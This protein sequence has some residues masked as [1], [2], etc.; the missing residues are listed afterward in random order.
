MEREPDPSEIF[1]RSMFTL[2]HQWKRRLDD[3]FRHLGLTQARWGVLIALSTCDDVTQI[4]LAR[5]MGI[6][7]ASLVRLL[8]GL[9]SAGLIERHSSRTDRRAKNVRLTDAAMP[10]IEEMKRI[11]AV[12]RS[13]LM[14]QVS[15]E[16]L[17]IATM[18]M[19]QIADQLEIM[20]SD[21]HG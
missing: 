4:E 18:V 8:D 13:E 7:A 21:Q 10:L 12:N 2:S 14:K 17:R 20:N 6:E 5:T 9:E 16:D 3:Q 11:A 19:A 1:A 15:D